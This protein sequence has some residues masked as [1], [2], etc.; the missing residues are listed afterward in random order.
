LSPDNARQQQQQQQPP[1]PPPPLSQRKETVVVRIVIAVIRAVVGLLLAL[2]GAFS[3]AAGLYFLARQDARLLGGEGLLL[4]V[5]LSLAAALCA[6]SWRLLSGIARPVRA[7][8][9]AEN[10]A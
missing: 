10:C 6:A 2:A 1:P 4:L 7:V 8:T 3:A 5:G 9:S